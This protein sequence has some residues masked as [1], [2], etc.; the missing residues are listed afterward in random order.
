M[1][2][3]VIL[4]KTPSH[5]YRDPCAIFQDGICHL[6]CTLV[7]Q[8]NGAQVM[9]LVH[10]IST[11]LI[12]FT[13]PEPILPLDPALNYSSPG[14]VLSAFGQYWLCFQT[15]PRPKGEIYGNADS[16]LFL[17]HSTDLLSWSEPEI[18]PVMGDI[19]VSEMGR[20]IDPF[21]LALP[22]GS[23]LCLFKQNGVS[24]SRSTDL[25]HWTFLGSHPCGENVCAFVIR[26]GL[27]GLLHSPKNGV[28]LLLTR[29]FETFQDC[30]ISM[31]DTDGA[32]WARD[33]V[34]AG[35]FLPRE[36]LLFFHGDNE[37]D[38]VFGASVALIRHANLSVL[39]PGLKEWDP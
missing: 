30:G 27:Y 26:P 24:I 10:S 19:P 35:F 29:D 9:G 8:Q 2:P 11:D 31:L 21:L 23:F 18:I 38:F 20:M 28:G 32:L 25:R 13:E 7:R 16:R 14:N 37:E 6:F 36:Q 4:P 15:Y 17:M 12:H 39:Y 33:R 5:A 22:D 3:C 34:T 1:K